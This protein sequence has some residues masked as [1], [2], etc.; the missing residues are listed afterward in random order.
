MSGVSLKIK[1]DFMNLGLIVPITP[2]PSIFQ[3]IRPDIEKINRL[4][5]SGLYRINVVTCDGNGGSYMGITKRMIHDR[6]KEHKRYI[7]LN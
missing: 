6:I 3:I 5:I 7:N 4:Q 1:R 2:N